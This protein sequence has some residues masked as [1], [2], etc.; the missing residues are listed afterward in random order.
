MSIRTERVAKLLQRDVADILSRDFGQSL[1]T[2]VTHVRVTRDL[3]IA[4]VHVSVLGRT[5]EER[6]ASF[7]HLQAQTPRVRA[8]VA[9]RLR[10]QLK[11]VPEL[12]FFLDES[13]EDARRMDELLARIRQDEQNA[14]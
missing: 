3:S 11:A 4:Y 1:L 10:H 6:Q 9:R 13:H 7:L 2:T 8:A 5:L 12:R 14:E